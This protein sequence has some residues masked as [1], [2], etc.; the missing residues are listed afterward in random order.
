MPMFRLESVS[1]RFGRVQALTACSLT[2]RPGDR[3]A[4]IGSNGSGKSTLLRTLHG[5]ARPAS[6][7]FACDALARQAMLFQRPYML[8]ASVLCNV[9][10][11]LWL[12][13][14]AWGA[15]RLQALAALERVGRRGC[16]PPV[17]GPCWPTS[18]R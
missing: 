7:E 6:G 13:G 9:A 18:C 8:R 11:G 2:I 15:A 17:A 3:L 1:V 5:L 4:L 10:L 16:P 12:Q 14:E